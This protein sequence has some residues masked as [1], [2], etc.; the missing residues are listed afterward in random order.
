[1]SPMIEKGWLH[2]RVRVG[3]RRESYDVAG[4]ACGKGRLHPGYAGRVPPEWAV[5][6]VSPRK[7]LA[8]TAFWAVEFS[9][10]I[11]GPLRFAG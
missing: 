1:M 9:L 3:G 8:L 7:P 2:G 11:A 4:K 10:R 5:G 6:N